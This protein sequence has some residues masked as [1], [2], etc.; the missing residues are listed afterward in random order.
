MAAA[1]EAQSP[2]RQLWEAPG[3]ACASEG[4]QEERPWEATQRADA[5]CCSPFL[6]KKKNNTPPKN[7]AHYFFF[8]FNL[9]NLD[10]IFWMYC[11][12]SAAPSITQS[13]FCTHGKQ[14]TSNRES[15][16][17]Q[18]IFPHSCT[19]AVIFSFPYIPTPVLLRQ[20]CITQRCFL[21]AWLSLSPWSPSSQPDFRWKLFLPSHTLWD[22][23][24]PV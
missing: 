16:P 4:N 15:L 2:R 24:G 11:C 12:L 18:S 9:I 10:C 23:F 19:A 22:I 3:V 13:A 5:W 6:E 7:Q 8:T 1:R 21:A 14:F 20:T 17:S